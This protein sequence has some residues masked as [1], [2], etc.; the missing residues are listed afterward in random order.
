MR[1]CVD[2]STRRLLLVI[3]ALSIVGRPGL[4][5]ENIGQIP[6]GEERS[7]D[8]TVQ[9][10]GRDIPVY[11]VK[12]APADPARRWKAMDDKDRSAEY[13]RQGGFCLFRHVQGRWR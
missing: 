2:R 5:Q 4:A 10:E 11:A 6:A 12:V 1:R 8:Y 13:L 7:K 9:V 3:L